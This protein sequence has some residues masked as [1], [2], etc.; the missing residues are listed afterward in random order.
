[1]STAEKTIKDA[2]KQAG[3][4]IAEYLEPGPRNCEQTLDRLM[5]VLDNEAVAKAI[6]EIEDKENGRRSEEPRTPRPVTHQH[7]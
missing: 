6:N 1:M 4:V 3:Q 5:L 7:H 2:V